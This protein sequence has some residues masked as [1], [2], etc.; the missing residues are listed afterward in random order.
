MDTIRRI[1]GSS[2][3]V[4]RRPQLRLINTAKRLSD[5]VPAQMLRGMTGRGALLAVALA[6][7]RVG[8]LPGIVAGNS[9]REQPAF[10]PGS[11]VARLA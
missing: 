11:V 9:R 8:A 3:E 5:V 6:V 4:D 2:R 7:G 10:P 1:M